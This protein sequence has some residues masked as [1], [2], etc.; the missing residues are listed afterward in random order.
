MW[1]AGENDSPSMPE[2]EDT[3]ITL[4]YPLWPQGFELDKHMPLLPGTEL[5]PWE[6]YAPILLPLAAEYS[7]ELTDHQNSVKHCGLREVGTVSAHPG[8]INHSSPRKIK[9][10]Y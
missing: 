9:C 8:W 2:N 3:C 7:Q 5:H 10:M 1:K 4:Q 6:S